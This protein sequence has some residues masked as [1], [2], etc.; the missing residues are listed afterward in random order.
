[1]NGVN[2][3][4]QRSDLLDRSILIGLERISPDL[5]RDEEEF[6]ATFESIR[7]HLLGGIFDLLSR[8]T[9]F[10]DAYVHNQAVQTL[11]A[12]EGDV[13]SSVETLWG[14]ITRSGLG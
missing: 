7:P 11:E 5:R 8:A 9:A 4:P 6:W 13:P 3:T 1:M 10:L 12:V 14:A 2:V